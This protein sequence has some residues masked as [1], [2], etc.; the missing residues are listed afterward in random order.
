MRILIVED[1][2]N[3]LYDLREAFESENYVVDTETQGDKGS[4]T[5]RVNEYD[6]IILD[7]VLPHKNGIQICKE[8]RESGKTS[9]IIMLTVCNELKEKVTAFNSG[10]DDYVR[11]PYSFE[12][13]LARV[14]AV[15]RR[16]RT[17]EESTIRIADLSLDRARQKVTR[18]DLGIYL[19]RKEFS[20]LEY[21]M[22]FRGIVV[23]RGMIMEHVW[24]SEGNPFSNTI[25][26]HILNL[27]RKIDRGHAKLIHSIP[28]RGYK[29]DIQR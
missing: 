5:G 10:A 2:P 22:R 8:I 7:N 27:R 4:Y 21:L 24:N 3:I 17:I 14:K 6:C 25:E 29:I 12:E 16:P 28:G 19:T 9:P 11:K 1:D 23:S 26:A 15:T 20:L 18:G 13:L